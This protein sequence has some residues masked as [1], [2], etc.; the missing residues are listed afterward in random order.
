MSIF[1]DNHDMSQNWYLPKSTIST[2]IISFRLDLRHWKIPNHR[3]NSR[4]RSIKCH[5]E[6]IMMSNS[7]TEIKWTEDNRMYPIQIIVHLMYY[8]RCK[9]IDSYKLLVIVKS[10]WYLQ[11]APMDN[12]VSSSIIDIC[13]CEF[14]CF[15]LS[16]NA[17][18]DNF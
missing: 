18:P 5:S 2:F 14:C 9:Q 15:K 10:Y 11:K 6:S 3:R 7:P 13:C 12:I 16:F 4:Y 17:I 1:Y 8:K